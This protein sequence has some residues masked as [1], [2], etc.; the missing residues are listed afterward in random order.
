MED[1]G[2]P[3]HARSAVEA[4]KN[5]FKKEGLRS[6]RNYELVVHK[7]KSLGGKGVTHSGMTLRAFGS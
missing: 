4:A 1:V 5:G 6:L 3:E 2:V 7:A